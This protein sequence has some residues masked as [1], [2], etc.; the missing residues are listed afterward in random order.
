[1]TQRRMLT[2]ALALTLGLGLIA[3]LAAV[4]AAADHGRPGHGRGFLERHDADG[5]GA[6]T[7]EE[8]LAAAGEMF[9]RLDTDGDG[10]LTAEEMPR[11]EHRRG[12]RRH[13]GEAMFGRLDTDGDGAVSRAEWDAKGT[14]R[15]GYDAE[16]HASRFAELDADGDGSLSRDELMAGHRRF[17]GGPEK[18]P[19]PGE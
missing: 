12:H 15:P 16:R 19:A 2:A 1:M 7:R 8:M 18:A 3:I 4:P 6:V 11:M 17:R 5:D 10:V 9:D 13:S 14:D